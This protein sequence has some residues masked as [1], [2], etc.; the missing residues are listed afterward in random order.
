MAR[1]GGIVA[2]SEPRSDTDAALLAFDRSRA[3]IRF[4]HEQTD[5]SRANAV[6]GWS[7]RAAVIAASC[8]QNAATLLEGKCEQTLP[9]LFCNRKRRVGGERHVC[10]P[11]ALVAIGLDQ[12]QRAGLRGQLSAA[13]LRDRSLQIG[14]GVR[15]PLHD[16]MIRERLCRSLDRFPL[17]G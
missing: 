8:T 14:I 13:L 1:A 12:R 6:Q 9:S 17:L 2:A 15:H 4:N 7:S 16:E 3:T 11:R 5:R 10:P